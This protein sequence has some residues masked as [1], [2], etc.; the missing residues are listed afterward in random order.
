[1]KP[2][3]IAIDGGFY[4]ASSLPFAAKECINLYPFNPLTEA[5]SQGGLLQTHGIVEDI[6]TNFA[7]VAQITHKGVLHFIAGNTLYS[8]TE[9]GVLTTLG[10]IGIVSF[11]PQMASNGEVLC[12]Q[13]PTANG[14]FF[15]DVSGFRQITNSV[16]QDYQAEVDGVLGVDSIDGYFIFCTRLNF[17]HTDLVTTATLGTDFPALAFADGEDRPDYNVR[18]MRFKG[19]AVLFG[20]ES[21]EV[22]RNVQTEP[23]AFARIDGATQDKGL[24][25]FGGVTQA[26]NT[27][28]FVGNGPNEETAIWRA[29]GFAPQKISTESIDDIMNESNGALAYLD[30]AWSYSFEGHVFVGFSANIADGNKTMVY[31]LTASVIQK[32]PIWH[33]RVSNGVTYYKVNT[34]INAYGRLSVG[35]EQG[36]GHY[37]K[38]TNTEF[39]EIVERKFSVPYVQNSGDP[40]FM[41]EVELRAQAG[42]GLFEWDAASENKN[43]SVL[44]RYSDDF[45]NTWVDKGEMS[46]GLA[47]EYTKRLQWR[48]FAAVKNMRVLEFS[49]ST[50]AKVAFVDLHAIM[51]RGIR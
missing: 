32:R 47:G 8:L 50:S 12:V 17:F 34:V 38:S 46:L 33:R 3:K 28:F 2:V 10:T 30:N 35:S 5:S 7:V 1:M 40:F 23:F 45:T 19:E 29:S 39:G 16:Y 13:V 27:F 37:D 14:Y 49:I 26:D 6:M 21:Y 31:D 11:T 42:V 15:D 20:T 36:L 41:S 22:W 51:E 44:C 24:A 9:A 25:T 48:R 4:E 18:P 43:P